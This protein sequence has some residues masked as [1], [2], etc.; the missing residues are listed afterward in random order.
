[1]EGG[2]TEGNIAEG[3]TLKRLTEKTFPLT[4]RR[5][6]KHTDGIEECVHIFLL[7][8]ASLLLYIKTL[9][10][11]VSPFLLRCRCSC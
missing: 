8:V 5:R 3:Q 11:S 4:K 7:E 2:G 9:Y 6:G 10:I 1:M